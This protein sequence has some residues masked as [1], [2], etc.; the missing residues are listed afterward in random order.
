MPIETQK[1]KIAETIVAVKSEIK[2]IKAEMQKMAFE[3]KPSEATA[4]SGGGEISPLKLLGELLTFLRKEKSMSALM[5]CRQISKIEVQGK[6]AIIYSDDD[7][8]MALQNN[9]RFRADVSRFFEGKGLG[10]KV[11]ENIKQETEVDELK[12]LLGSKLVIK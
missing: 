1:A 4:V 10:F 2:E 6:T 11:N 7:E 9:D 3:E 5:L 12:R 8:M